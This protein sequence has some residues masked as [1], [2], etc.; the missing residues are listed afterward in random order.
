MLKR[1][2]KKFDK[3]EYAIR[4]KLS[5]YPILYAFIGGT[6]IVLFW[7]GVWHI[8]DDIDLNSGLSL[9]FGTMILLLT[10]VFVAEFIGNRLI[11]S[12]LVGEKKIT[13]KEEGVIET[14]EAQI[15]NLQ[16]TLARLEKKLDHIDQE[17]EG[18]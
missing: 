10:G 14:E 8:A 16:S 5:N 17:V 1:F 13:E 2:R 15:K 9:V 6:G 12:G 7:R 18:K 11:I 3:V 4:L